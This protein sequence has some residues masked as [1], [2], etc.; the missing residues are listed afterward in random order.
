MLICSFHRCPL[1]LV[2][3]VFTVHD[4]YAAA[5]YIQAVVCNAHL[6]FVIIHLAVKLCHDAN[7]L[8]CSH[9]NVVTQQ[10]AAVAPQT[11]NPEQ[12]PQQLQMMIE[13]LKTSADIQGLLD[14]C[15]MHMDNASVIDQVCLAIQSVCETG[16]QYLI[17]QFDG[18]VKL[19]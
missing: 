3:H 18:F 12:L 17:I 16:T 2:C 19:P 13:Q 7:M 1:W 15:K 6:Y 14:V 5:Q 8:H 9:I 10:P 4:S 11:R